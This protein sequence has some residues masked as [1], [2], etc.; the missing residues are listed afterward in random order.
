MDTDGFEVCRRLK[1]DE[2]T[3][4]IPA[5]MVT[6]LSERADRLK[7]IEAGA[8][9]FLTKPMDNQEVRLRVRNAIWMKPALDRANDLYEEL[10][11]VDKLKTHLTDMI[12][13][14]L[15]APPGSIN[16]YLALL[17]MDLKEHL[18]DR[19]RHVFDRVKKITNILLTMISALLEVG[20]LET[21]EMPIHLETVPLSAIVGDA[22]TLIAGVGSPD[23][24]LIDTDESDTKVQC[25]REIT[26]RVITNILANALHVSPPR[27][28]GP[29]RG[30]GRGQNLP[31]RDH[32]QGTWDQRKG[33]QKDLREVRSDRGN[34]WGT[35]GAFDRTRVGFLSPR[36]RSTGWPHWR[37]KCPG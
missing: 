24:V 12:I 28:E 5:I 23:Q 8:T 6:S 30:Q 13:H 17:E 32:R 34:Q 27:R 14:D 21:G 4:I 10:L 3:S 36:D 25:D 33:P 26:R 2:D 31:C 11:V 7:G 35:Q 15:R 1:A 9:D 20:R 29:P 19:A 37:Q 16:G 22:V 18:K